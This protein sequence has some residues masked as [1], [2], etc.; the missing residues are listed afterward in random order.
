MYFT[1]FKSTT[2]KNIFNFAQPVKNCIKGCPKN[3]RPVCGSNKVTYGNSCLFDI[4]NCQNDGKLTSKPGKCENQPII[5]PNLWTGPLRI[6]QTPSPP[7]PAPSTDC[8]PGYKRLPY[9]TSGVAYKPGKGPPPPDYYICSNGKDSYNVPISRPPPPPP[10]PP[11]PNTD[12][13][14]GYTKTQCSVGKPM[15]INGKPPPGQCTCTN[16]KDSYIISTYNMIN[17]I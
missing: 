1:I 11:A 5:P 14:P 4:A 17:K 12:C 7:P 15:L 10:P 6:N 13:K 9:H 16:G 3:L 2:T 8:K